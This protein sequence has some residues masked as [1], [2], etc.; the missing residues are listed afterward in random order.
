MNESEDNTLEVG[1]TYRVEAGSLT[2]GTN[3]R[4]EP[5]AN[6]KTFVA[7]IKANGVLEPITAYLDPAG[8]L[9]VYR[10]QRRTLAAA[11]VGTPDGLVPVRVV[12]A[13]DDAERI[14]S[15]LVENVHRSPMR[16]SE[17]RDAIEQLALLGVSAAQ[18]A[19]RTAL[20]RRTVDAALAVVASET[21]KRRMDEHG[22]T[23]DQAAAFAEFEG[24]ERALASLE[25]A[26][27]WGRSIDHAVQR[28]RDERAERAAIREEVSRLR[29]QGLPALDPD[30][31]PD[32]PW[33]P[34]ARLARDV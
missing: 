7:S 25:Q 12:A 32:Q 22:L 31:I 11:A 13:P 10:G 1:Q 30:D 21:T 23:L 4:S 26:A 2:I 29:E 6:D 15:Q 28:L 27:S 19:K 5:R 34:A 14:T 17:E 3:V 18:I 20:P 8:S 16:V 24:D 33:K 9:V